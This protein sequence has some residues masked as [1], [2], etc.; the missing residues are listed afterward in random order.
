MEKEIKTINDLE[1]ALFNCELTGWDKVGYSTGVDRSLRGQQGL[2]RSHIYKGEYD[3]LEKPMCN[4]GYRDKKNKSF[5][6]WR[7][8]FGSG[9]CRNCLKNTLK[10]LLNTNKD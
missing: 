6:I 4:R 8:N 5:S 1:L 7:N 10:V 2:L 9:I 3:N